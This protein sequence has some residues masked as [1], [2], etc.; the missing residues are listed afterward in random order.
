ML[1]TTCPT[2]QHFIELSTQELVAKLVILEDI[3]FNLHVEIDSTKMSP[4]TKTALKALN[5][6]LYT[7]LYN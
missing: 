1:D 7:A 4:A 6:Q 2:T 5:D 3:C